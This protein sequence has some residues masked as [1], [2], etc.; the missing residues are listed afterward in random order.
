[1][2]TKEQIKE[3]EQSGAYIEKMFHTLAQL[4]SSDYSD[5]LS[6]LDEKVFEKMKCGITN[7]ELE[8]YENHR[9][10]PHLLIDYSM[11]GWIAEVRIPEQSNFRFDKDGSFASCAVHPGITRMEYIFSETMDG[12][13]KQTIDLGLN[14][15]K[16][17]IIDAKAQLV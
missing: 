15:R 7:N 16:E 8:E 6:D 4:E 3:M 2:M 11:Y 10:L 17:R 14:Y 13:V 5:F 12:I 9:E 1:M